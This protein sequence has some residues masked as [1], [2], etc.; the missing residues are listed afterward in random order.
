V[1]FSLWLAFAVASAAIIMIPGPTVLIVV[2]QS[3]ALGRSAALP[4]ALAVAL[5]DAVCLA[6]VLIGVGSVLAVSPVLF[7]ALTYGG[8]AYLAYLGLTLWRKRPD[9]PDVQ[10]QKPTSIHKAF[11]QTF[12]IT[13][14]NPKTITFFIAFLPQ[15]FDA[16]KPWV[17]QGVVLGLTFATL[18]FL[19]ASFYAFMASRVSKHPLSVAN[20][21]LLQR[22]AG[23]CLLAAGAIALRHVLQ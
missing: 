22:I 2:S 10:A 6:L 18:G 4:L 20:R 16:Q 13:A 19:N 12:L 14:L 15:F 5:G 23:T 7:A 9:K 1:A 17:L 11:A 3:L 8:A 21:V